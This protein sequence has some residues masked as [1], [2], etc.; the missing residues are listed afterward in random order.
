M[1]PEHT[2]FTVEGLLPARG[3]SLWVAKPKQG[4]ST[5]LRQLAL[6]VASGQPFLGREVG[7]GGVLYLALEEKMSEVQSHLKQLGF[8]GSQPIYVHCGAIDR[9]EA[10]E[11]LREAIE[12]YPDIK[13]VIIDPLFRFVGGVRDSNDYIAVNNALEPLLELARNCNVHISIAHHAKKRECDDMRDT[14]LGSQALA[15]GADTLV[16]MRTDRTGLRTIATTQR[17]GSDLTETRLIWNAEERRM[18]I[19]D[20]LIEV[21]HISAEE[22]RERIENEMLDHV[23]RYPDSTQ[24]EITGTARG[25]AT[26]KREVFNSIVE[27]GYLVRSGEGC[28]GSPYRYRVPELKYDTAAS[29]ELIEA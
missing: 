2:T 9:N 15:G 7:Q 19:G 17:Y 18:S 26:T 24:P 21:Q 4:K 1:T 20:T 8:D 28:K 13:L 27:I 25:N 16:Y 29:D 5:M 23:R 22:T 10:L 11:G 12:H 3:L 6:A 14:I